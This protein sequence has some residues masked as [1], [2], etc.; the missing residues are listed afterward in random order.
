MSSPPSPL[1]RGQRPGGTVVLPRAFIPFAEDN[2]LISM[3][4]DQMIGHVVKDM[5]ELLRRRRD[6]HV[7]INIAP[8]EPEN[9]RIVGVLQRVVEE[10]RLQPRQIVLEA[11]ERSLMNAETA[12][13][14]IRRLRAGH[15]ISIND[16]GIGCSNLS[17]LQRFDL[18]NLKIERL[19]VEATGA[20]AATSGV[21]PYFIGMARTLKLTVIAEG[22]ESEEQTCFLKNSGVPYTQGRHFAKPMAPATFLAYVGSN[23]S[24]PDAVEPLPQKGSAQR[25]L[26]GYRRLPIRRRPLRTG[27]NRAC[28]VLRSTGR[29]EARASLP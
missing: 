7:A 10:S 21:V 19:F 28:S 5:G 4:T 17:D 29:N 3:I 25:F 16:S 26:P 22:V 27:A 12:S 14:V 13:G 15:A 18:D 9:D 11:T 20:D 23:R 24:R 8:Q 2:G 6:F 1:A